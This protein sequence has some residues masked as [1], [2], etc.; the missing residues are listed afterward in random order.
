V[1]IPKT[2]NK[3]IEGADVQNKDVQP[4]TIKAASQLENEYFYPE[5]NGYQ[6]ITI[7]AATR[8]D[9]HAIYLERRKPVKVADETNN[10]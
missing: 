7:R 4:T 8:Q 10:Q 9:A 6:A 2:Q 5:S 1:D 3:M